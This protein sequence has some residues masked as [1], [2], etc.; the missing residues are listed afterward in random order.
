MTLEEVA[1]STLKDNVLQAVTQ[2]IQTDKWNDDPLVAPFYNV[3]NELTVIERSHSC[4]RT[5][6]SSRGCKNQTIVADKTFGG[7][8][9][10]NTWRA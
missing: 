1:Q 7:P 8:R 6:R 2:S 10:I 5:S 4:P 3:R 9:L